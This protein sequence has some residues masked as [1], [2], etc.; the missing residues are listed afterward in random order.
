[1]A[2]E[3]NQELVVQRMTPAVVRTFEQEARG[4][5]DPVLLGTFGYERE[6]AEG[7]SSRGR[8][9]EFS[10]HSLV[11]EVGVTRFLPTGT[12]V[13]LGAT[14]EIADA[15]T[16]RQLV[17]SR[18]GLTVTQALLRGF[19]TGVNLANI[20]QA[21]LDTLASE[22]ELRGF[23]EAVVA[24][25]E[26]T[27]WDYVLA[28][29]QLEIYRQSVALAEEQAN[30]IRERARAGTIPATDLTAAESELAFRRQDIVDAGSDREKARIRL[31]RLLNPPGDAGG[32]WNRQVRLLEKAALPDAPLDDV[33]SH[34]QVALRM[35]PDLNQA[36]LALQR[37]DLRLVET[38]GGLLP[39]MDLFITLGRS[40]YAESFSGSLKNQDDHRYDLLFGVSA[41]Y[42][43][44]NH[45]ARAAHERA[46][47][48]RRQAE[49]AVRNLENLVQVDVRTAHVEAGRA[50]DKVAAVA[51]TR[52]L[53][54]DKLRIEMEKFLAGRSSSFQVAR[55]QRD[56]VR[57]QIAE[58]TTVV[59]HLKA[60]VDLYRLEGSLLERRGISA[61]GAG[62][63][64][65]QAYRR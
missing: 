55:A 1:M 4:V 6:R 29:R 63:P 5:F 3:H 33:E 39:R 34:V 27:C 41:E 25:V 2:I 17:Q 57:S 15:G 19:G 8:L 32:V 52:K 64:K 46:T 38:R 36:R 20:R 45:Q 42:P 44:G 16:G 43:L 53:D 40:G 14:T 26:Q 65:E 28:E 12:T 54:E 47:V 9:F 58:V 30:V 61:P 11:G 21:R 10:S 59:E 56:L 50:R 35:R 24:L 13:G 23:S 60:L 48:S 31:L 18:L 22:Y 49:E 62:P 51:A 7:L 37:G